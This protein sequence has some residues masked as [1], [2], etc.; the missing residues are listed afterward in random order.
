MA[1]QTFTTGQV[2]TAAQVNAL[3]LN[4]YNQT[5]SAKVASYTLVAAD[6]GTRI[7]MSNASATTITV[8]TSLFA[9]GDTLFIT[10][11]GV[12]VSTITAG[13][14]TVSTASSLALAQYDSGS[15]YFTSAGV[16]IWQKYQGAAAAGSSY[17]GA[18]AY[19]AVNLAYG[20]TNTAVSD[21]TSEIADTD[22]FHSTSSNTSRMTIPTGKDGKYNM[23]M[24]VQWSGVTGPVTIY[25]YKNGSAITQGLSGGKVG[26]IPYTANVITT[27]TV[28]VVVTGVAT[29]YFEFFVSTTTSSTLDAARYSFTYLGA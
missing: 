4:D 11:I 16:A 6:A 20:T 29:D 17:V 13:T 2:L 8:N 28:G 7:T 1:K 15:L 23:E 19:G 5:V 27:L 12:G 3:Q 18:I 10:N 14:A 21:L 9:P 26:Q 25:A 24:I 22:S